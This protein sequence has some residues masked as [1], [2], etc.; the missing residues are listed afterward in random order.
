LGWIETER[1]T[2]AV[3]VPVPI[4]V[5]FASG[6]SFSFSITVSFSIAHNLTNPVCLAAVH[7]ADT[8]TECVAISFRLS[9]LS[10]KGVAF[11]IG[12]LLKPGYSLK[13]RV[14]G[15]DRTATA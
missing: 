2:F 13:A 5:N 7:C 4:R 9:A 10:A 15:A 3:S 11:P 6:I 12:R 1:G 8:V 14:A